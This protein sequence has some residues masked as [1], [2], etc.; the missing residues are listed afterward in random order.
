MLRHHPHLPTTIQA[1]C[2]AAEAYPQSWRPYL[3]QRRRPFQPFQAAQPAA[4]DIQ[5]Q[6]AWQRPHPAA[7][8]RQL[9]VVR[10]AQ[11]RELRPGAGAQ[12]GGGQRRRGEAVGREVEAA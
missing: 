4:A 1:A 12:A 11:A 2:Q 10:K 5:A 7:Q 8:L 9:A 3:Q 6:Q